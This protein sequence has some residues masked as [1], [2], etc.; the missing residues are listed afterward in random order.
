M[1]KEKSGRDLV[2]EMPELSEVM[3]SI[4]QIR[5][6]IRKLSGQL[7]KQVSKRKDLVRKIKDKLFQGERLQSP[8]LDYCFFHSPEKDPYRL[9]DK[10]VEFENYVR[11][12]RGQRI[13][14]VSEGER[15]ETGI[16]SGEIIF[17]GSGKRNLY[18]P[19]DLHK[20]FAV[21]TSI[22]DAQKWQTGNGKIEIHP[23]IF[24]I[25]KSERGQTDDQMIKQ[26]VEKMG[27]IKIIEP[28]ETEGRSWEV[29]SQ[30]KPLYPGPCPPNWHL[31]IGDKL[32]ERNL[33]RHSKMKIQQP[34]SIEITISS[35]Y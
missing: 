17:E 22:T 19:T 25:K 4:D 6:E 24:N 8:I 30:K 21:S 28:I 27:G 2:D 10:L 32:V 18:V 35:P 26:L 5:T 11:R 31:Y 16:V 20:F 14:T 13:L 23:G 34:S 29:N 9:L 1:S 7:I 3:K 15:L 12:Y 33:G